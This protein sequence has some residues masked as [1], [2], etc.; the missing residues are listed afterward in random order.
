[1]FKN[2]IVYTLCFFLMLSLQSLAT[3][4]YNKYQF[5][6][7]I[8]QE[9]N[10]QDCKASLLLP[11]GGCYLKLQPIERVRHNKIY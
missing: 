2:K 11:F 8:F 7:A 4:H 1:M 3:C 9:L 5:K 10:N 6:L